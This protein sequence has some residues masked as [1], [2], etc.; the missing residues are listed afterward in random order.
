MNSNKLVFMALLT[1][2]L[3]GCYPS[4]TRV[5]QEMQEVLSKPKTYVGSEECK[6]CHLEH[7]DSWK[8]TLH[9]RTI[10]D[11]TQNRD[12]LIAEINPEIIRADLKKL[13]KKLKVPIDK[14]YIPKV[15]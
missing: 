1:F 11:V 2:W 6:F 5:S 3:A 15:E 4:E 8:T 7:Y 13:E 12:A 9:S 10:M 14:I